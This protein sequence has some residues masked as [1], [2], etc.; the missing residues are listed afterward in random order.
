M[1]HYYGR[2][3]IYIGLSISDAI[4]TSLLEA[5]VMGAFPIQSCT[6]CA[7]EWIEDGKSGFIVPPED[8]HVIAEAIRRALRPLPA[9]LEQKY[10]LDRLYEDVIVR[11]GVLATV[12]WGLSLWDRYVVDG[13]ANGTATLTRRGAD[14]LRLA[15][16]GQAQVYGAAIIIGAVAATVGILLVH[17]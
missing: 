14:G 17:P 3:R 1:L 8:P 10:Y 16:A 4:S 12:A 13:I 7:D 5:M 6:A 9:L 15:Q 2:A 11:R